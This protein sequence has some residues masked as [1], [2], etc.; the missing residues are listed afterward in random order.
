MD[1]K[2]KNMK[3]RKP[4]P[5]QEFFNGIWKYPSPFHGGVCCDDCNTKYVVPLR[6]YQSIRDPQ[7]A[8]NFKEDGNLET[9]KPKINTLPSMNYKPQSEVISNYTLVAMKIS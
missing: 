5:L 1:E 7:Y 6:I 8:L 4:A 9:L 2:G 3:T